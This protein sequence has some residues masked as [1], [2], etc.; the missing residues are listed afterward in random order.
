V[1]KK[2]IITAALLLPAIS[3]SMQEKPSVPL[4]HVVAEKTNGWLISQENIL[5]IHNCW[6]DEFNS[7]EGDLKD[8]TRFLAEYHYSGPQ[9][10]VTS[11]QLFPVNGEAISIDATYFNSFALYYELLR[12]ENDDIQK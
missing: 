12:D 4:P 2:C 7:F 1:I 10:G 3:Y 5:T 11:C 9:R 6:T 8:G